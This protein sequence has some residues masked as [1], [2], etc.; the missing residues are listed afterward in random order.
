M[1]LKTI[2]K[3]VN[4]FDSKFAVPRQSGLANELLSRIIFEK[5]YP[6]KL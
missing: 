5:E 1:E 2:A 6:F 4:D 3:I